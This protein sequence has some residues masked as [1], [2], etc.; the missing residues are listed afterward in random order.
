[1]KVGTTTTPDFPQFAIALIAAAV[2]TSIGLM[3]FLKKRKR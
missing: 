3:V 2:T 1:M